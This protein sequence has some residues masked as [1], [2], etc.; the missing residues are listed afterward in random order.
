MR[1]IVNR[2]H[3]GRSPKYVVSHPVDRVGCLAKNSSETHRA[4]GIQLTLLA[5]I[6]FFL[7]SIFF[8]AVI[9]RNTPGVNE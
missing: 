8:I 6:F 7:T 1:D 3:G 9:F 2:L 4:Y 5:I